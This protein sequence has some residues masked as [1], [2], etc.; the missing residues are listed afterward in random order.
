VYFGAAELSF[1]AL[2]D[3]VPMAGKDF[4]GERMEFRGQNRNGLSQVKEMNQHT[5][6]IIKYYWLLENAVPFGPI[7]CATSQSDAVAGPVI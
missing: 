2:C 5:S 7:I 4:K 3:S 1:A 6:S